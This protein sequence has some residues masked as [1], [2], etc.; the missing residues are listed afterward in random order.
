ML[1]IMGTIRIPDG[2]LDA[3]RAAMTAMLTASR[4]EDGCLAYSY[5]QDVLDSRVI[6]VSE[7]WRDRAALDAH[8]RTP[9]LAGWRAQFEPLGITDRELTLYES[10]DGR[11]V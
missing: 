5:A 11:P 7:R 3:A 8:F 9:H 10:G 4:G 6:H 2:G 1:L